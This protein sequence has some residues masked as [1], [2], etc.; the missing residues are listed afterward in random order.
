MQRRV[1]INEVIKRE[2]LKG[3]KLLRETSRKITSW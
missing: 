2:R 3:N 1:P